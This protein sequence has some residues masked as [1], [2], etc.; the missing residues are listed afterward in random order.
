MAKEA[1]A[2]T[3]AAAATTTEEAG[4]LDQIIKATKP[5]SDT[6]I[7]SAKRMLEEF[8]KSAVQGMPRL[9]RC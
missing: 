3:Q 4:F 2:Q 8:V 6:Q 9:E 7:E 1:A 5:R